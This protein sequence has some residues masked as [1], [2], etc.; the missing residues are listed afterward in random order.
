[1]IDYAIKI[2]EYRERKLLT[3]VECVALLSL[4]NE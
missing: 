3:H 4:K 1:M 2:K